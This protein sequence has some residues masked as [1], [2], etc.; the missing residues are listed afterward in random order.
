MKARGIVVI[1]GRSLVRSAQ[2]RQDG[3][4]DF[5][6]RFEC[7]G[8]LYFENDDLSFA[9]CDGGGCGADTETD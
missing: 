9:G 4:D 5:A 8:L 3:E 6:R 7:W 1:M 2:R